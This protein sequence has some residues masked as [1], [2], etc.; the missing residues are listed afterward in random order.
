ME[1]T[2]QKLKPRISTFVLLGFGICLSGCVASDVVVNP[3]DRKIGK[4]PPQPI[5]ENI[6]QIALAWENQVLF[7]PNS[8]NQGK[9]FPWLTGRLYLFDPGFL[10]QEG[11]GRFWV[12]LYY[13]KKG[14]E[15]V[16]LEQWNFTPDKMK[17]FFRKDMVG[18]G[19]TLILPWSTYHPNIKNV[20]LVACYTPLN[21]EPLYSRSKLRIHQEKIP[22]VRHEKQITP[23]GPASPGP[24]VGTPANPSAPS[25]RPGISEKGKSISK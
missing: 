11:M 1:S 15:R 21:S 10:P 16:F 5:P 8:E 13:P 14:G 19:Y 22:I 7:L 9:P 18:W 25:N 12:K 17:Q 6:Q 20:E 24:Q 3:V 23:F 4:M 2:R